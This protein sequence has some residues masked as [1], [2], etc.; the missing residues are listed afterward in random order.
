MALFHCPSQFGPRQETENKPNI[1]IF[2]EKVRGKQRLNWR[3]M[4]VMQK[5]SIL[6][7]MPHSGTQNT[8]PTF[9]SPLDIEF[10][11]LKF[12]IL[13]TTIK[14]IEG[15]RECLHTINNFAYLSEIGWF[16]LYNNKISFKWSQ[17]LIWNRPVDIKSMLYNRCTK[18]KLKSE[19][20]ATCNF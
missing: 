14:T 10:L 15:K 6:R 16:R 18:S 19:V 5:D 4:L 9:H 13:N 7:L 20:A 8:V 3:H 2:Q 1:N 12:C 11:T 17:P